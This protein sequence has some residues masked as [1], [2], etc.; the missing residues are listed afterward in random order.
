MNSILVKLAYNIEASKNYHI[1]KTFLDVTLIN[2]STKYKKI[3]DLSMIFLVISTV[4]ILI[5]EVRHTLPAYIDFFEYFA[6]LIFILEW[7][8]RFIISFE[9]HKQIIHDYEESQF[10]D[11]QYKVL[12]SI[13]IITKK[14]LQ[15]V[16]SLTSIID[17]LAILPSYRPLRILRILLLFRLFKVLKYSSSINTF[18]RV[19][20]E[21]KLE[22]SLLLILYLLVIFFAATI[23]YLYEGDGLN[24]KINSFVDAIYWSFITVSTIGYGD[25]TPMSDAGRAATIILIIAGYTVIAFFT[26]IVTSSISEKLDSMKQLNMM[27]NIRK[28]KNY[29]L[30]CGYGRTTKI[31]ADNLK[32]NNYDFMIIEKDQ[33]IIQKYSDKKINIIKGDA[34]DI[35][36]L[37]KLNLNHNLQKVIILTSDDTVNLSIILSVRSINK[38]I[39]I[40]TRSNK[41]KIQDKLFIA[42]AN[43]IIKLND[44]ASQV[45]LGYLKS[46]IAYEAIEN[47]LI[48]FVGANI[49][50]IELFENSDFINKSLDNIDFEKFNINFIGII[51]QDN[52]NNFVFNPNK[53]KTILYEKD[54]LI[55]IGYKKTIEEFKTYIYSYKLEV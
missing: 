44:T 15:Y 24:D 2:N 18:M 11:I 36:L 13:K 54:F 6:V 50:E 42:G 22:L 8:F 40:I 20:I 1:F 17:L 10:L 5:Y 37:K 53:T 19:F 47:I 27:T 45:A 30:I 12:D 9:S 39:P 35:N 46:P 41:I 4:G 21:K 14:K 23:I 34:T 48:D 52:K 3:F 55:V 26:S 32:E 25:I 38:S 51:R 7:I 16:F 43:D 29:I 33:E 28:L 49:S 31:L